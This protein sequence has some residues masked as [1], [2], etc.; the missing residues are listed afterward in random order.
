MELFTILDY[1]KITYKYLKKTWPELA[2]ITIEHMIDEDI[3]NVKSVAE[4]KRL[5]EYYCDVYHP[6]ETVIDRE[7]AVE[8]D[9]KAMKAEEARQELESQKKEQA[10]MIAQK[11]VAAETDDDED[12]LAL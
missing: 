9:I 6:N 7:K 12:G 10:E 2:G 8:E 11:N 1:K 4:Y 3:N 5:A